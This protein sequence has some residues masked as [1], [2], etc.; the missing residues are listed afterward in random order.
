MGLVRLYPRAFVFKR[1]YKVTRRSQA[2]TEPQ[3]GKLQ[4]LPGKSEGWE[5]RINYLLE[6][7]IHNIVIR[8][9]VVWTLDLELESF[10]WPSIVSIWDSNIYPEI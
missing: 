8:F 2:A 7:L 10:N 3:E 5:S 9:D 1:F 4:L 6:A